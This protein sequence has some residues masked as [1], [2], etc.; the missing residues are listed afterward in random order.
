MQKYGVEHVPLTAFLKSRLEKIQCLSF[1][2]ITDLAHI[3]LNKRKKKK[4]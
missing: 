4:D 2:K 3:L 1:K